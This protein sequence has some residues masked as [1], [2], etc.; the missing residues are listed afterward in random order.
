MCATGGRVSV[1]LPRPRTRHRNTKVISRLFRCALQTRQRGSGVRDTLTTAVLKSLYTLPL[2]TFGHTASYYRPVRHPACHRS[3]LRCPSHI[4][5]VHACSTTG[6]QSSLS[7]FSQ[8]YLRTFC[9]T[10]RE[11]DSWTMTTRTLHGKVP[12]DN[13][14][15]VASAISSVG[16]PNRVCQILHP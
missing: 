15:A 6:Q 5:I 14:S 10:T 3:G 9:N 13:C 2:K 11:A 4:P 12:T 7:F 16:R 1:L 8:A